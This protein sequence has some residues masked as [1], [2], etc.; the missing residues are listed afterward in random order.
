MREEVKSDTLG[1]NMLTRPVG[2]A[3]SALIGEGVDIKDVKSLINESGLLEVHILGYNKSPDTKRFEFKV[4]WLDKNKILL[5]TKTTTWLPV[6]AMGHSEFNF[7]AVAPRKEAADYRI[8]TRK[9]K[10]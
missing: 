5:D 4:E 1:N 10:N 8:D 9:D 3:F 6:S 7:K 2:H